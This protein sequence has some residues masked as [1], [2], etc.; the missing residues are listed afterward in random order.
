MKLIILNGTSGSGKT[1]VA[2][3]LHQILPLSV[4][5][6]NYEIRRM[7]SGFADYRE[8][9]R[10][11]MFNIIYGIVEQALFSNVDVIVDSK[12][13][14][15]CTGN[16]FVDRLVALG[17]EKAAVTYEIIL[18]VDKQQSMDRIRTRGFKPG[19]ILSE[20]NLEENVDTFLAKMDEYTKSR[21]DSILVDTSHLS[22]E[23]VL[24]EIKS[25]IVA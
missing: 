15:D 7:I 17:V 5:I 24:D 22:P 6:P 3:Q 20:D 8:E 10:E 25:I 12:I 9:S 14:D 1:T 2:K 16:S 21:K 23:Q 4:M 11:I 19:A 13:H 18:Q